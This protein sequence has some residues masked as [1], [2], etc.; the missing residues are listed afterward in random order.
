[1]VQALRSV[2]LNDTRIAYALLFG[3]AARRS[4]HAHSDVDVAIGTAAGQELTVRDLGALT[5]KLESAVGRPVHLV[6][7]GAAPP[8]LAYRVFRDGQPL[9]VRDTQAMKGRLA[10]A[11]LEYLDFRPVEEAFTRGVLRAR[12]GR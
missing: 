8:G 9:V 11:I 5:S 1:V 3:S 12:H 6:L 2:L 4:L 10:R 7:L